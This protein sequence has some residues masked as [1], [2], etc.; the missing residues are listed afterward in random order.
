MGQQLAQKWKGRKKSGAASAKSHQPK[1][2]PQGFSIYIRIFILWEKVSFQTLKIKFRLLI[3]CEMQCCEKEFLIGGRGLNLPL[4]RV[5][6]V[7]DAEV[8]DAAVRENVS[9][10]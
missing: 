3:S 5:L 4:G 2:Q 6:S 10:V 1:T 8:A 9:L 7:A